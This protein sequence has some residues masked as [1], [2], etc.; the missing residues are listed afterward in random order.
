MSSKYNMLSIYTDR[1]LWISLFFSH[2]KYS[3]ANNNSSA[4][5]TLIRG[6]ASMTHIPFVIPFSIAPRFADVSVFSTKLCPSPTDFLTYWL[7][8]S[9]FQLD[10]KRTTKSNRRSTEIQHLIVIFELNAITGFTTLSSR[11]IIIWIAGNCISFLHQIL[12]YERELTLE[13]DHKIVF[14]LWVRLCPWGKKLCLCRIVI[15]D[16]LA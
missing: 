4:L 11:Y 5:S 10:E 3:R 15:Q 12:R 7:W 8:T 6:A 2:A 16:Q 13:I 1:T 9:I 14:L